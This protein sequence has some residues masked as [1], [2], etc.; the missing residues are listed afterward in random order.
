MRL[1][2]AL[3]LSVLLKKTDRHVQKRR[4]LLENERERTEPLKEAFPPSPSVQI[5]GERTHYA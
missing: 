4:D 5:A 1:T 2:H 3:L